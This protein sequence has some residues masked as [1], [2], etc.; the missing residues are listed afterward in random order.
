MESVF[1][2][3]LSKKLTNINSDVDLEVFVSY[4]TGI[5]DTDISNEDKNESIAGILGEITVR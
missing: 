2:S 3:W 4:I 1:D 5:L